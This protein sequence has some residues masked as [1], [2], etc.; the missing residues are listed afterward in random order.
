MSIQVV[1]SKE[2]IRALLPTLKAATVAGRSNDGTRLTLSYKA[3]NPPTERQRMDAELA[4]EE[5][6]DMET[7]S[8]VLDRV[9]QNAR[10]ELC[11]TI[12]CLERTNGDGRHHAYRSFNT[13]RGD[14]KQLVI[15]GTSQPNVHTPT[16][17]VDSQ[18]P[19]SS[20]DDREE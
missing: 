18:K 3:F 8:G 12:L 15:L 13:V 19:A 17:H 11:F 9:F 16:G 1:T 5:G 14:L 4:R 10:G 20:S 6:L 2:E 7:Y